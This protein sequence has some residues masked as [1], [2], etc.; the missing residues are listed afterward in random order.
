MMNGLCHLPSVEDESDMSVTA[1]V[2]AV[3]SESFEWERLGE[4]ICVIVGRCDRN[5]H[6]CRR[7]QLGAKP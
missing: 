6:A 1:D 2:L 3:S 4:D 7:G 5:Y